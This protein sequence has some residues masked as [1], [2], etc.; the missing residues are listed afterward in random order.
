MDWI[1]R[2]KFMAM[3]I[4]VSMLASIG[5]VAHTSRQAA[6]AVSMQEELR[7]QHADRVESAIRQTEQCMS[8]QG[9]AEPR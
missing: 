5:Y 1:I 2:P 3:V 7:S 6:N 9:D 8:G 4:V